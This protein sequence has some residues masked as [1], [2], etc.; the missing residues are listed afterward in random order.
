[1]AEQL[2]MELKKH[3]F[4]SGEK[5]TYFQKEESKIDYSKP[6]GKLTAPLR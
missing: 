4:S 1:M 6:I 5:K 3:I 2:R